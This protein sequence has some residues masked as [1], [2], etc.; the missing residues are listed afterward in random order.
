MKMLING[1]PVKASDGSEIEVINPATH[2]VTDTVPNAT[3]ADI[4]DALEIAQI[5]KKIWRNTSVEE[6]VR[7]LTKAAR[8]IEEHKDELGSLLCREL[9]R[10]YNQCVDEALSAGANFRAFAEKMKHHMTEILPGKESDLVMVQRE[11]L[12]VVICVTPFNFPLGLYAFKAAPALAAGNAVIVKPASVTP[13]ASIRMTE[14]LL[15]AGV[16]GEA[17]QIVTGSGENVGKILA[18][19]PLINAVSLTGSTKVGI[20]TASH[21]IRNLSRVFLELGGNDPLIILKDADLDLAVSETMMGRMYNAGQVCCASKRMLVHSKIA[22]EYIERLCTAFR[23]MTLTNPFEENCDMGPL[24]SENAACRV[25]EQIKHTLKQGAVCL[26]GGHRFQK[27]Y[28]EPTILDRVTA[29]MDVA[30]DMEIFGPVV[31]VIRFDTEEEAV[32]IANQTQYGL[33]AG[34]ITK[35]YQ[36]G[37]K[38]AMQMESGTAVVNGC[39]D[40]R[41]FQTPFGGHKQSG[42]GTEGLLMTLDE[43]MLTKCVVLKQ[44]L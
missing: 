36:K 15:E 29:N 16:P 4:E 32:T 10:P 8:N 12:G 17:L 34:V 21:A 25:E 11:P 44:I 31:P 24:I 39:G 41:T 37:L 3:Q 43:M 40:Y 20:E 13:L 6:R 28:F 5:G 27:S 19:S 14:L 9:G 22:D 26:S 7:I 18:S 2:E 35:D 1:K 42:I 33:S 23:Q 30:K 38:L